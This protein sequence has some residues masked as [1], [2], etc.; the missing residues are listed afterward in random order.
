MACSLYLDVCVDRTFP[1]LIYMYTC[2]YMFV[3]MPLLSPIQ[4]RYNYHSLYV[5]HVLLGSDIIFEF[6]TLES[7]S[8]RNLTNYFIM[9][10][11]LFY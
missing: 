11:L 10:L 4:V 5:W 3:Q 2:L 1:R 8:E 6:R 9:F 7:E